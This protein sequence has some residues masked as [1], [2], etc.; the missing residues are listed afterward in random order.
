VPQSEAKQTDSGT[1]HRT[2]DRKHPVRAHKVLRHRAL[3]MRHRQPGQEGSRG[4]EIVEPFIHGSAQRIVLELLCF[5]A[6]SSR[7]PSPLCLKTP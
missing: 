7:E 2:D 1:D 3:R 5:D 6:F 4:F